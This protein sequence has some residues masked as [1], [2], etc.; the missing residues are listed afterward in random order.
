[1]QFCVSVYSVLVLALRYFLLRRFAEIEEWRQWSITTGMDMKNSRTW[2]PCLGMTR[3]E[4]DGAKVCIAGAKGSVDALR[5]NQFPPECG[6]ECGYLYLYR[7]NW[8]HLAAGSCMKISSFWWTC[9]ASTLVMQAPSSKCVATMCHACIATMG[10]R[11]TFYLCI[12]LKL[13]TRGTIVV[14]WLALSFFSTW[15]AHLSAS[16]VAARTNKIG[17]NRAAQS[18]HYGTSGHAW[19]W[20]ILGNMANEPVFPYAAHNHKCV[21]EH[22][23]NLCFNPR[24]LYGIGLGRLP[25]FPTFKHWYFWQITMSSVTFCR[26]SNWRYRQKVG[27]CWR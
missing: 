9:F 16:H 13:T 27:K 12:A 17:S 21:I 23:H 6:I 18:L 8:H 7:Q 1:M 2:D 3:L 24:N 4:L 19:R 22:L 11:A 15:L 14:T 5:I 26:A 20:C 10:Q 25:S